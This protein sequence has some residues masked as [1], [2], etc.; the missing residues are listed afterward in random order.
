MTSPDAHR[1]VEATVHLPLLLIG[2]RWL[3]DTE[4]P[5][6][7]LICPHGQT[8]SSVGN[9]RLRFSAEGFDGRPA[10]FFEVSDTEQ[11]SGS[12][13]SNTLTDYEIDEFAFMLSDCGEDAAATRCNDTYHIAAWALSARA[14]SSLLAAVARYRQGCP[15][16]RGSAP[17][18]CSWYSNGSQ[19]AISIHDLHRAAQRSPA[20]VATGIPDLARAAMM[21]RLPVHPPSPQ[22]PLR[23]PG[24]RRMVCSN[25]FV[26]RCKGTR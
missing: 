2:L 26:M 16:H 17:S 18:C 20:G 10:V 12:N 3:L 25:R 1:R 11:Q 4:Q 21:A 9:R 7:A 15:T 5:A 22:R 8:L 13:A 19:R 6:G 24:P 23:S 14:P